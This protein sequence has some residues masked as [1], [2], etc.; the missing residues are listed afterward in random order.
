MKK[1]IGFI[2]NSSSSSFVIN[3]LKDDLIRWSVSGIRYNK[4][5][6]NIGPSIK[7][8]AE[9]FLRSHMKYYIDNEIPNNIKKLIKILKSQP[10]DIVYVYFN[11]INYGTE[12]FK[13]EDHFLIFTCNNENEAWI[14]AMDTLKSKYPHI[15]YEEDHNYESDIIKKFR[16]TKYYNN[17]NENQVEK[18]I[19]NIV[20]FEQLVKDGFKVAILENP[21]Y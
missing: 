13:Y 21:S 12:I 19:F 20:D 4:E 15:N 7:E 1:R 14:E 11:S 17:F 16:Q 2:S 9:D 10:D 8:V 6:P 3:L 18:S 5:E